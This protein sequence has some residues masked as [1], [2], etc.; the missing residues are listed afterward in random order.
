MAAP[1]TPPRLG[2]IPHYQQGQWSSWA[3]IDSCWLHPD[4]MKNTENCCPVAGYHPEPVVHLGIMCGLEIDLYRRSGDETT[5]PPF[6]IMVYDNIG[7]FP[8][9]LSAGT[10]PDALDLL[11]RWAPAVTADVVSA[12]YRDLADL[13]PASTN[14]IITMLATARAHEDSI[15]KDAAR[16]TAERADQLAR[17]RAKRRAR[18]AGD[19]S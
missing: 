1:L 7:D 13:H 4:Q 16:I 2:A 5:V 12:T 11:G 8:S 15:A 9:Y 14:L 18:Q 6:L 19:A 10:L 3:W 17:W